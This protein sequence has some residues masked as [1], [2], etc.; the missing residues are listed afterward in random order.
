MALGDGGDDGFGEGHV[1]D[2]LPAS[3][4]VARPLRAVPVALVAVEIRDHTQ[5]IERPA[6]DAA[7]LLPA[8]VRAV[9]DE[10]ERRS[11]A[12]VWGVTSVYVLRRPSTSML[13]TA[14]LLMW[15]SDQRNRFRLLYHDITGIYSD[16][17]SVRLLGFAV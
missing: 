3:G 14:L 6:R 1:V 11:G 8:L 15:A 12:E 13:R 5:R 10:D 2:V 9:E 7:Y 17:N 16:R 4:E